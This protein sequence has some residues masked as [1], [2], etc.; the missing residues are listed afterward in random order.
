M[1]K[2]AD[3]MRTGAIAWHKAHREEADF[4]RGWHF[5]ITAVSIASAA[6]G[7]VLTAVGQP[8]AA[9]VAFVGTGLTAFASTS[10]PERREIEHEHSC[11]ENL[12]L[13][14]DLKAFL[15]QD[16]P[17]RNPGLVRAR[18]EELSRRRDAVTARSPLRAAHR[19][20]YRLPAP[21]GSLPELHPE[22]PL[23][24]GWRLYLGRGPKGWQRPNPMQ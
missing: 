5:I 7:L 4:W 6:V 3:D 10:G 22:M 23:R 19:T 15:D 20:V 9:L 18:F 24:H 13:A 1:C 11:T 12:Q 16:V 17:S 8:V 14:D 2:L 21:W